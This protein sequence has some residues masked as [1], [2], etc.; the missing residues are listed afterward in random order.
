MAK[1]KW[2][3]LM[4]KQISL[5]F[6]KVMGSGL[7]QE[8]NDAYG[9]RYITPGMPD[10]V[11][12]L[13]E[14][15]IVLL[16][17]DGGVL[18]IREEQT[19]SVF[20]RIQHDWFF[21]GYGSGGDVHPPY[22]VSFFEGLENAGIRYNETLKKKYDEW[23]EMPD[24]QAEE[25]YWGH[26]P[27]YQ[28]EMPLDIDTVTQAADKSDVALIIIGRAAGEDRE[29]TLTPGSYFLTPKEENMLR[30]VTSAF[31][32]TV[33]VMDCGNIVD[34][35]FAD[36]Y[37]ISS[38]LYAWQLGQE[39][40]NAL[41]NVLAGKV[42]PSGKLSDTIA[43]AYENY[44]SSANFGGKDYNNYAEDIYV[45]YRYFQTFAPENARYP[46]G[47][48]L[49]YTNFTMTAEAGESL[50]FDVTVTNTGA[51]SGKEVA[52][53]YVSAPDGKLGKAKR[54]LVGYKKTDL[55]APGESQTLR[56]PVSESD[57]A[58]FDDSGI[59]GNKDCFV[60]EQGSY[61]FHLGGDCTTKN[62]VY[63]YEV[64]ETRVVCRCAEACIPDPKV[65]FLHLNAKG[66]Q[67]IAVS[68]DGLPVPAAVI[69]PG[70]RD[71]RRRVLE[72][73]PDEIRPTGDQGIRFAD[74]KSGKHTLDAFIAQLSDE[75]LVNLTRGEGNM[76]SALGTEGNAGAF[77]GI[78][79]ALRNWGIPPVIT[80]DG[81]AGLRVRRYT[82]LL[83]CGIAIA[84]TWNASLIEETFAMVGQEAQHFCIHVNLA[85]G[86]NIHRDPLCGRNF[87]YYS[88]DP[89]LSGRTAAA[90]VR[91]LQKGGISACP[92]HFACNNQEFN[93]NYNDT[94]IS[95]RALREIYL[96]NFEYCVKEGKPKN[97]MTSY[98]KI[99]GVWSHYNY[100]LV[101]TIL[102]G[103]WGYTGNVVTDWW[104]RCDTMPEFPGIKDNAYRTRAQVD[105]LMPGN[106]GHG[107]KK[108]VFD[109]GHL[110]SLSLPDG[111][112]RA[113]LQRTA[114]NVL[115]MILDLGL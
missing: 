77:G 115:N 62:P 41:A 86:M 21:V 33:L 42:T 37:P 27:Y 92:K 57:F 1:R 51:V 6:N 71:L 46:F 36:R 61:V 96:K 48:G 5:L 84:C 31:R 103:E 69:A 88:E 34:L 83:P 45:G 111:L 94:R 90:A 52:Q 95:M 109:K 39:N 28:E 15:G 58:S 97:I 56:I 114:K 24:N 13:A 19:V 108:P 110:K 18:P 79:E 104:M 10:Q 7:A 50:C 11:R 68:R 67:K 17:N 93:R 26:W 53:L 74:V 2:K 70:S 82:T 63:T 105:V 54:V 40:A 101:T 8:E 106:M 73:L 66:K 65:S 12:K 55:L 100:D 35:S 112:T 75:D 78:T 60:L 91:G 102:R 80:A 98:N 89:M 9:Q 99:N 47:F 3:R 113:E 87:E 81:P 107:S 16:K 22:T 49:S 76:G 30:L 64:P 72:N 25:G 85:P 43:K 20:G 14:E 23:A 59:T 44:P 32:K 29:N 38:I 4:E